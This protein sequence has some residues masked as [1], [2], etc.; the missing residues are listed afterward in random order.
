MS[1]PSSPRIG[2]FSGMLSSISGMSRDELERIGQAIGQAVLSCRETMALGSGSQQPDPSPSDPNPSL[3]QRQY[4][5][6][7]TEVPEDFVPTHAKLKEIER[8]VLDK[9]DSSMNSEEAMDEDEEEVPS[10]LTRISTL[11]KTQGDILTLL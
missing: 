6:T 4:V 2:A 8:V 11:E 9:H 3:V 7:D 1:G 5:E 10:L